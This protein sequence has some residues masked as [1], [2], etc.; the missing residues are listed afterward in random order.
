MQIAVCD[1][2]LEDAL[3]LKGLLRGHETAIY[4]RTDRLL[5]DIAGKKVHYDLYLLDIYMDSVDA[6]E[7][8]FAEISMDGIELAKKLRAIDGEAVICFV[9]TS[10]AF[11]REAYDLYAMQYLLKPVRE[12]ALQELLERV[13]KRFAKN[14]GK[15]QMVRFKWR[16]QI[17]MIPY[18]K[19][20][21]ISSREHTVSIYCKDGD[22]QNCKSKLSELALQMCDG[23]FLRCH[24]SFLVNI[25]QVDNL[26]GNELTV[27]GHRIPVS[28]RYYAE[29]K[30]RYQEMLFEEV[31]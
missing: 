15:E 27:S 17:G 6:L 4:S 20:L 7:K 28:R 31:D 16:G 14:K 12:E 25:Y 23:T 3:Y 21:Y 13:E 29:V 10:S 5:A 8:G 22:V 19:I 2:V 1:D 9:S 18:D 24:Q 26:N 30:R 11:Y